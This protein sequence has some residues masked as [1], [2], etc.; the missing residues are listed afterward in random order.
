MVW[1]R[2]WR[3]AEPFSTR[4]SRCAHNVCSELCSEVFCAFD[5]E[6]A[7]EWG[8]VPRMCECDCQILGAD[9]VLLTA[10]PLVSLKRLAPGP[11][12]PG[13]REKSEKQESAFPK[14]EREAPK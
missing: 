5:G 10:S 7:M 6:G 11:N 3:W 8:C 13:K 14:Q 9:S 1:P 12:P 4:C 2:C